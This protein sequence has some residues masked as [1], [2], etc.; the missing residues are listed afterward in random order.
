[1]TSGHSAKETVEKVKANA[2]VGVHEACA[3]HAAMMDI[4]EPASIQEPGFQEWHPGHPEVFKVHSIMQVTKHK[5]GPP[6]QS[7]N[8]KDLV[9]RRHAQEN[10]HSPTKQQNDCGRREP[11]EANVTNGESVVGGVVIVR[12]THGLPRAIDQE[13]MDQM[14]PAEGWKPVT[15]QKPV[16]P[17]PRKLRDNHGIHHRCN[18]SNESGVKALIRHGQILNRLLLAPK[19]KTMLILRACWQEKRASA[20]TRGTS[21]LIALTPEKFP[22]NP[23]GKRRLRWTGTTLKRQGTPFGQRGYMSH[24]VVQQ[25]IATD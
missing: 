2:E 13:M 6:K 12:G 16:Q 10:H 18:D 8:G 14:A 25:L 15:V 4:V 3:V 11:F 21:L 1:M 9:H 5:K 19:R 17:V 20:R 24:N 23:A 7:A 22:V